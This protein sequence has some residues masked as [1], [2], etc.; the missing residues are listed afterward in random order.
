M[1]KILTRFNNNASPVWSMLPKYIKVFSIYFFLHAVVLVILLLA[2][3]ISHHGFNF[4]STIYNLPSASISTPLGKV[5]V[6]IYLL[7]A[8]VA[9]GLYKGTRWALPL[10][11]FDGLNGI[12]LWLFILLQPAIIDKDI[13]QSGVSIDIL[14][15]LPYTA[16]AFHSFPKIEGTSHLS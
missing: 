13:I 4:R 5:I 12:L 11:F 1:K 14:F 8:L 10:A 3:A 7:K 15:L 2:E 16:F 9:W 6:G